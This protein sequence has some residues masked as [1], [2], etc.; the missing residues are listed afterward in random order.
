M[1]LSLNRLLMPRSLGHMDP[2]GKSNLRYVSAFED[3]FAADSDF[4]LYQTFQKDALIRQMREFK[5]EKIQL[6]S[7]VAELQKSSK[8]HDEHIRT[9]DAWLS[10]V[11]TVLYFS[12]FGICANLGF[13]Y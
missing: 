8:Y 1:V 12:V 13:S 3:N 5:R 7:Q 10:Q 4:K 9:I 2:R 6:E 11:S